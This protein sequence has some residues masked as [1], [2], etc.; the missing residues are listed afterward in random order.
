MTNRTERGPVAHAG[1]DAF[2]IAQYAADDLDAR[3]RASAEQLV[4]SCSECAQLATDL[5]LIAAATAELPETRRPRAFTLS[6]EQADRLRRRGFFGRF[7]LGW[8]RTDFGRTLAAGLTT[9]GLAGLLIGVVPG[10]FVMGS[11][12]AAPLQSVGK[13]VN[14]GDGAASEAGQPAASSARNVT[15]GLQPSAAASG[16]PAPAATG[17]QSYGIDITG[18]GGPNANQTDTLAGA[19]SAAAE[20]GSRLLSGTQGDE[21][22]N[23]LV[24]A[25]LAIFALG[26]GLFVLRRVTSPRV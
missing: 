20:D 13:S 5:R 24:P 19:P 4:E 8:V 6:R 23:Y 21:S 16:A 12:G 14:A 9:L 11:S 2:L 7:G 1:H 15:G 3:E 18:G 10:M 26:L 25:S 17:S 22:P